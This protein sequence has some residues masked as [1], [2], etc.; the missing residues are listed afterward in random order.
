M[1]FQLGRLEASD[2]N[3]TEGSGV[4][5]RRELLQ[6]KAV[7]GRDAIACAFYPH[8]LEEELSKVS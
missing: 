7:Q 1:Y 2:Q 6:R 3:H 8:V 5:D 4:G